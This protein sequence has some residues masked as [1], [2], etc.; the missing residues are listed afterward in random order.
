LRSASLVRARLTIVV[1]G[2]RED[3]TLARTLY[4][5]G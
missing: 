1:S 4:L 3:T 5:R 2:A